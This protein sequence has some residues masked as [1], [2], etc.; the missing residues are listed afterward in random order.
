MSNEI[1][2]KIPD[3]VDASAMAKKHPTTFER[4]DEN[5]LENL[6][7]G[8]CVKVCAGAERFWVSLKTVGEVLV[9]EVDNFLLFTDEH[10]LNSGD[11]IQFHSDNVYSI[12][13]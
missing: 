2:V 6:C 11:R 12:Y 13:E 3:I 10:G 8:Q 4:P 7:P 5:E 1:S 9:G